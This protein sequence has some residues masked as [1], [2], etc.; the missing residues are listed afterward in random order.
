M[1]PLLLQVNEAMSLQHIFSKFRMCM[2]EWDIKHQAHSASKNPATDSRSD[3]IH[4]HGWKMKDETKGVP[5]T[6]HTTLTKPWWWF[7]N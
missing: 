6:H 5:I 1:F 4:F 2:I 3:I 7:E